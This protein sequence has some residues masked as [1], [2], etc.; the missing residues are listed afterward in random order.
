MTRKSHEV[1]RDTTLRMDLPPDGGC[2]LGHDVR[3]AAHAFYLMIDEYK[4]QAEG[5]P[6]PRVAEK[7][8]QLMAHHQLIDAV[9]RKIAAALAESKD[10][11][12]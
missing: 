1:M 8:A 2:R 7:L 6:E 9:A 12:R 3:A 4:S 5:S 10:R 11:Q